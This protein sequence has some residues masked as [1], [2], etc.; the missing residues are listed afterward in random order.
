MNCVVHHL[1]CIC[2]SRSR[3]EVDDMVEYMKNRMARYLFIRQQWNVVLLNIYSNRK[4]GRAKE[5]KGEKDR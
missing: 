4:G 5:G 1:K 3:T 2:A